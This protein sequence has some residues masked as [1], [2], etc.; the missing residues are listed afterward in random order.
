MTS[1]RVWIAA[2]VRLRSTGASA[3]LRVG[4]GERGG[5]VA[6]GLHAPPSG[7]A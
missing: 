4:I 6:L 3:V 2:S 7:P 5:G 1:S